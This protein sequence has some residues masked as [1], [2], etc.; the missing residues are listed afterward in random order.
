VLFLVV[1]LAAALAACGGS[2]KS[3]SQPSQS[4]PSTASSDTPPTA[5]PGHVKKAASADPSVSAKMICESEAANDIATVL[6]VKTTKPFKP[7]WTDH[8]YACDYVYP[9]GTMKMSVKEVSTPEE[10]TAYYDQLASKLD[11]KTDL[12]G[13]G[14]GAFV[15]KNGDVVVRKDY[16]I[17][18]IDVQS[19]PKEFGSPPDTRENDAI[20]VAATIM[21]CWTGA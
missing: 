20:N 9:N 11:K 16:K 12:Q 14:D 8:V 5:G 7:T 4:T 17:L 15:A 21:G 13:L 18:H 3:Q 19:L 1:A 6:G 10:T 2:S